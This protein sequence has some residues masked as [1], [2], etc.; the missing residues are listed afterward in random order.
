[1]NTIEFNTSTKHEGAACP[2]QV[3][4]DCQRKSYTL[5]FLFDPPRREVISTCLY[6]DK[7][8]FIPLGPQPAI[9]F[10]QR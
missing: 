3:A 9:N 5:T 2:L 4:G 7:S 8:G 6:C 10:L 1:M